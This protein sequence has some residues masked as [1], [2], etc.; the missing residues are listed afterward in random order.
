MTIEVVSKVNGLPIVL[1]DLPHNEAY[2]VAG[3][4]TATPVDTL[5]ARF[6]G[7]HATER[8]DMFATKDEYASVNRDIERRS[9][10]NKSFGM[11][12]SGEIVFAADAAKAAKR[13]RPALSA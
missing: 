2:E 10:G 4:R 1:P 7:G 11:P 6:L 8:G 13:G 12:Q 3:G 9:N 5:N